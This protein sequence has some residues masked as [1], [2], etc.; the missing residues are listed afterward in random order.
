MNRRDRY[1]ERIIDVYREYLAATVASEELDR[2]LRSDPAFLSSRGLRG[3]VA[4][5]LRANL[6]GTYLI[7]MFASFEAGLRDAWRNVFDR[8]TEP[9]MRDLIEAIAARTLIPDDWLQRAHRVRRHR[10]G[11]V[12]EGAA[13]DV[14][15]TS[16]KTSKEILCRFFSKIPSDW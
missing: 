1:L 6:E 5:S 4:L 15:A 3:R 2:R 9:P 16:I 7:R 13:A 12:H 8:S 10:N 11:L 14:E